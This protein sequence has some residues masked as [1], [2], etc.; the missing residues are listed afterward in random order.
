[1]SIALRKRPGA[2]VPTPSQMHT[3]LFADESG[4]PC[5][6]DS[7]GVVTPMTNAGGPVQLNEQA[8]T[9]ATVAGAIK[10]YSKDV[11]GHTEFFV[12]DDVG[13]EI[14]VTSNG[15]LIGGA[16]K[17]I[18]PTWLTAN[19][20]DWN[21]T[22]IGTATIIRMSSDSAWD[23]TGIEASG[24]SPTAKRKTLVNVGF[25]IITLKD[26]DAGSTA[27]NQFL[28]LG[29]AG[30]ILLQPGDALDVYYDSVISMW[31]SV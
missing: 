6:K 29:G 19:T 21:P 10:L 2:G 4:N 25:W 30:D 8:A 5:L 16:P 3:T 23:L 27:T 11:D 20:N 17:E 28:L 31:R 26:E 24:I 15:A 7:N 12:L 18:T 1:M 14:Q 22:D 13:N 9:P